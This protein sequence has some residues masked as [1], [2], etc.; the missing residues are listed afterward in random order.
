MGASVIINAGWYK[1]CGHLESLCRFRERHSVVDHR[2]D[3][4]I[5]DCGCLERLVI[6]QD[7]NAVVG[8]EH[9]VE[10]DFAE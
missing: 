9:G 8:G 1:K 5:L 7:Q 3:V 10:A 4:D 6:N 2:V